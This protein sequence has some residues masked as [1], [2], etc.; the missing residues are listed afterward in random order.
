M[1]GRH[2]GSGACR[3][4]SVRVAAERWERAVPTAIYPIFRYCILLRFVVISRSEK[5]RA[6]TVQCRWAVWLTAWC[7]QRAARFAQQILLLGKEV[8]FEADKVL[9]IKNF[10]FL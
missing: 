3:K 7:V 4:I 8:Y 2:R 10:V 9:S 5:R 6:G 1:R